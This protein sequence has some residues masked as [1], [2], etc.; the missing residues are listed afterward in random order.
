LAFSNTGLSTSAGAGPLRLSPGA[1]GTLRRASR[2]RHRSLRHEG[3]RSAWATRCHLLAGTER[4]GRAVVLDGRE[5]GWP[6]PRRPEGKRR[7][8]ITGSVLGGI[9]LLALIGNMGI[10]GAPR[11]WQR[12]QQWR[13]PWRRRRRLWM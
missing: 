8:V 2:A 12:R 11:P 6:P 7:L 9:L 5:W 13:R 10:D 1:G 3:D 4:D